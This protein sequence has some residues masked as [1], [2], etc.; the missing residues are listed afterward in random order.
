MINKPTRI[1]KTTATAT[2]HIITNSFIPN[3]SK[4]T[5]NYIQ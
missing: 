4:T 3:L 1:T 5:H 2:G